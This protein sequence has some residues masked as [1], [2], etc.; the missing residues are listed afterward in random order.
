M[1]I[2]KGSL[3]YSANVGNVLA[4][5]YFSEKIFTY[6]FE[7][8]QL[9]FDDSKINLDNFEEL[10]IKNN[11]YMNAIN[12]IN[13]NSTGSNNNY[14]YYNTNNLS[15]NRGKYDSEI[16]SKNIIIIKIN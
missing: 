5:I 8:R 16:K 2:K 1:I 3:L 7:V 12:N 13:N 10:N 9:S 11:N 14:V 4:F 6:K 15:S